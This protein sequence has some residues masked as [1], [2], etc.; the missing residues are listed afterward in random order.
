MKPTTQLN[1]KLDWIVEAPTLDEQVARAKTIIAQDVTFVPFLRMGVVAAEKLVGLPEGMPDTYKPETDMPDGV[2]DTAARMEFRRIKN[3]VAEG[4]M[5]S[6]PAHRRETI[7]VQLLEGMHWKEAEIL[8]HIKDQTLLQMYPQ[9]QAIC[10]QLGIEVTVS[11]P[12][13]GKGKSTKKNTKSSSK[14]SETAKNP[15]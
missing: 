1:E 15:V 13:S 12:K 5:A 8:V 10:T 9:L 6:L 11:Q 7:W 2:A 14:T 3:F 4:S